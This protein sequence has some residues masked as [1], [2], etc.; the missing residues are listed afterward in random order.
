VRLG[1]HIN[2]AKI[3]AIGIFISI[4]RIKSVGLF[5]KGWT[6]DSVN[7]YG[8]LLDKR[9]SDLSDCR[10]IKS[11]IVNSFQLKN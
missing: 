8:V 2:T 4:S 7:F 10:K 6:G 11:F 3:F 1:G 5:P 9:F